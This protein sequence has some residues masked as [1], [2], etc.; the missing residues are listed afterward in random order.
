MV[1]ERVR[2]GMAPLEF[3]LVFP[4]LVSIGAAIVWVG[5]SGARKVSTASE[6]RGQAWTDRNQADAGEVLKLHHDAAQSR[7]ARTA[8]T[9]LPKPPVVPRRTAESTTGTD[10]RFWSIDERLFADSTDKPPH[11]IHFEILRQ[12]AHV[13]PETLGRAAEALPE[14]ERWRPIPA[15]K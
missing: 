13:N 3:V 6:A 14:L 10:F 1:N 8:S 15:S 12:L 5:V 2:R 4:L 11:V 9:P 7:I